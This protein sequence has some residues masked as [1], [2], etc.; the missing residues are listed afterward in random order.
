MAVKVSAAEFAEKHARRLKA[1][2]PDIR[3][4]VARVTEN[5]TEKAAAAQ[6]KMIAK[7]TESVQSGKWARGLRRVTLEEWKSKMIDKGVNRIGAGVDAAMA[8]TTAFAEE[9]IA[10]ENHLLPTVEK[11][12]DMT[13]DDSVAR[14]GAWIRGMSEFKRS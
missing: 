3:A 13:I 10:F 1:S 8:K 14:A 11:M 7:L 9:L 4:G 2:L 5:P 6:D 12:P